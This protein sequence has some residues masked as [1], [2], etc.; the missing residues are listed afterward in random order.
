MYFAGLQKFT[1]LDYPEKVACT[2]FTYGCNF[3]CPFCHNPELVWKNENPNIFSEDQIYD[4]MKTRIGKLDGIAVTG[5]EP[6]LHYKDL[7]SFLKRIKDLGFGIKVDTNGSLPKALEESIALGVV[8]YWAMDVKSDEDSYS[9]LIGGNFVTFEKIAR[10]MKLIRESGAD[11]EFRTTVLKG[12]H[13]EKT[14]HNIGKLVANTKRFTIQNYRHGKTLDPEYN[15]SRF[16]FN[17]DELTRFK[18]ILEE[19]NIG[20]IIVRE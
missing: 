20:T 10:S 12:L 4:F 17:P 1:L 6:L 9:T 11:Y 5:G 13:T 3:R 16:E 15:S 18:E 7:M 2:V 8:D 19:Y 14:M